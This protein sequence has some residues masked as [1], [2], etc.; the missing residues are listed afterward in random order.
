MSKKGVVEEIHKLARKNFP[1]RAVTLK[2]LN[3]LFQADL[4]DVS[5]YKTFNKNHTFI[6][7]VINCFTKMGYTMP[8]KNK[9]GPEVTKAFEEILSTLPQPPKNLQTDNGTEFYNHH[10]QSLMKKYGINHYSTYSEKKA[11]IV[12]RFNRTILNWLFKQF[13]LQGS[14]KWIDVLPTIVKKYNNRVHRTTGMKPVNVTDKASE[15]YLLT[16]VYNQREPDRKRKLKLDDLVR[17]SKYKGVFKKG[18]LP[19]WSTELFKV[20]QIMPTS[21]TSFLLQDLAGNPIKGTFYREELQKTK[22]PDTYL[23]EKILRKKGNKL[24]V[25]WLGFKDPTWI[26]KQDLL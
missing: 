16:K 8:L 19:N 6:L 21:P 13:S 10:F 12:E 15:N 7:M 22:Y 2:G 24:Y 1:T 23:V 4:V 26:N 3:D 17:L 18:Y 14:Y 5:N 9:S 25:R 20:V 11:S